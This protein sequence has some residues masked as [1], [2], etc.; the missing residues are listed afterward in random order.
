M[1]HL[2]FFN[3][4]KWFVRSLIEFTFV[5]SRVYR[6][7]LNLA[8][9]SIFLFGQTLLAQEKMNNLAVLFDGLEHQIGVNYH[10]NLNPWFGFSVTSRFMPYSYVADGGHSVGNNYLDGKYNITHFDGSNFTLATLRNE[11]FYPGEHYYGIAEGGTNFCV[12]SGLFVEKRALFV[13]KLNVRLTSYLKILRQNS[14]VYTGNTT[15][16]FKDQ[17]DVE[18]MINYYHFHYERFWTRP[19]FAFEFQIDYTVYKDLYTG[20]SLI[21]NATDIRSV[22]A[23]SFGYFVV[24]VRF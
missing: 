9:I 4:S 10:R 22:L 8:F 20:I 12:G 6:A 2:L 24:G 18:Y 15:G 1:N 16:L 19:Y 5:Y 3:N 11:L 21:Y 14:L 23:E 7:S 17:S 13:P